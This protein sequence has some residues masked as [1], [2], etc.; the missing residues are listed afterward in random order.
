LRPMS[1]RGQQRPPGFVYRGGGT[2]GGKIRA[3]GGGKYPSS[4]GKKETKATAEKKRVKVERKKVSKFWGKKTLLLSAG[5]KTKLGK[6]TECKK[7]IEHGHKN[8]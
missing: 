7:R 1:P 8:T 6:K 2:G 3:L 5:Q 4:W